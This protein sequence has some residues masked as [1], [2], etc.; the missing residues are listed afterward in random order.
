MKDIRDLEIEKFRIYKVLLLMFDTLSKSSFTRRR[1]ATLKTSY[2]VKLVT[3]FYEVLLTS[4]SSP[5]TLDL[6][7]SSYD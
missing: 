2:Q 5:N 4:S 1:R 6:P 7:G 3:Y